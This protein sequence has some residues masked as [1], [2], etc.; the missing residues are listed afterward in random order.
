MHYLKGFGRNASQSSEEASLRYLSF[1]SDSDARS[2]LAPPEAQHTGVY[3]G[4]SVYCHIHAIDKK[5]IDP[6]K[7]VQVASELSLLE[8]RNE[9][10]D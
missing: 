10:E 5:P 4:T 1:G 8:A 2:F 7:G 6:V 9:E 3:D